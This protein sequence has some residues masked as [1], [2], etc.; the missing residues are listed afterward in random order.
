M[1]LSKHIDTL[2]THEPWRSDEIIRMLAEDKNA[3]SNGKKMAELYIE[4]RVKHTNEIIRPSLE[5]GIF[6][7]SDRYSL[8][9]CMYQKTQ[10]IP[11]DELVEMHKR[12]EILKPD[13]TFILNIRYECAAE[14]ILKRGL[15]T[16]KFEKNE[17][18]TKELIKN[19][20]EFDRNN[21]ENLEVFGKIVHVLGET[22]K[23]KVAKQ[24][25]NYFFPI[26]DKWE[27]E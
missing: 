2:W 9:T 11:Y 20:Q 3:F 7:I 13:I 22:T 1:Y 25:R 10:G 8:S 17:I 6:V 12:K 15:A 16:E 24:I 14:R 23:E 19:Y 18:F 4:D 21:R 27:K 26:Y 5:K